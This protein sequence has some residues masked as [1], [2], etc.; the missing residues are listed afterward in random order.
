MS[1]TH[2]VAYGDCVKFLWHSPGL[3]DAE[4]DLL[5]NLSQMDMTRYNLI[6]RIY[7]G[8]QGLIKV[9]TGHTGAVKQCPVGGSLYPD[10]KLIAAFPHGF[11]HVESLL[12]KID[13]FPRISFVRFDILGTLLLVVLYKAKRNKYIVCNNMDILFTVTI[14]KKRFI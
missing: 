6:P 9:A 7:H 8:D 2:T 4:F 13:V 10:G 5:G 12:F 14:H 3:G 11:L 1:L